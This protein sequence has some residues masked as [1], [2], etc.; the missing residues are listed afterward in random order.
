MFTSH[1]PI[2]DD[3]SLLNCAPFIRSLEVC[4]RRSPPR[5]L[6]SCPQAPSSLAFWT[7]GC[8]GATLWVLLHPG[9]PSDLEP[10]CM[11]TPPSQCNS[12]WPR[13][14]GPVSSPFPSTAI[15]GSHKTYWGCA[16]SLHLAWKQIPHPSGFPSFTPPSFNSDCF[17]IWQHTLLGPSSSLSLLNLSFETCPCCRG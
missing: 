11:D 16:A 10:V 2:S 3:I 14:S 13:Q 17:P 9:F 5:R 15:G 7:C 6:W 4:P 8:G 1:P 12:G